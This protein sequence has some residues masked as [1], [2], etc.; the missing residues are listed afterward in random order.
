MTTH[1]VAGGTGL[2]TRLP[3]CG[4]RHGRSTRGPWP[5]PAQDRVE[6]K[7]VELADAWP[8]WG[9]RRLVDLARLDGMELSDS[10]ALRALKRTGRV[11]KP[12]YTREIR[13]HAHAR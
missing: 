9:H 8:E 5:A 10:T 1:S 7:L 2:L 13:R 6:A 12:D 4:G 3:I 11:L